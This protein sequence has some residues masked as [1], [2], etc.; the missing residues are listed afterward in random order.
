RRPAPACT[1]TA[2]RRSAPGAK[3]ATSRG[4]FQNHEGWPWAGRAGFA[5]FAHPHIASSLALWFVASKPAS[6]APAELGM[7]PRLSAIISTR[8]EAKNIAA[9]LESVA[10]CDER[11]VV[12]SGSTDDTV[13][14]AKGCGAEVATHEW[15][16]FGAQKNVAL[17]LARG[18]WVL[19][20]DADERVPPPL[21]AEIVA[22]VASG[23]ADGYEVP[24]LS[25]F[26]GRP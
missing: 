10:C 8:N 19:S 15:A 22:A 14:I 16:G 6:G 2:S 20:I 4:S 21:A 17:S 12:D 24:R 13:A 11:I 23:A 25:T 7:T 5:R 26:L 3:W 9:C 1:S 18:D